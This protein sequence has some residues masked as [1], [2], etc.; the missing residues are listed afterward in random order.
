MLKKIVILL[1]LLFP[2]ASPVLAGSYSIDEVRI[3]AW[4]QPDGDLLVNEILTYN[5]VGD[6]DS[7]SRAIHKKNHKGVELFEAYEL[8][9]PKAELGYVEMEDLRPLEVSREDNTY[10]A[11]LP[12]KDEKKDVFF[13]YELKEAVKTYDSYSDLT[14]PF[15]G[16]D[17][18]H[19]EDLNKVTIDFVF[20][21]E[22]RPNSYFPFFH[23]R[24]GKVTEK[25]PWVVRFTTPESEMYSLTETRL[26]FPSSVMSEQSK[27][28]A[29]MSLKDAIAEEEQLA[30][31]NAAMKNQLSILENVLTGFAAFLALGLVTMLFMR[32]LRKLRGADRPEEL[33]QTDPLILYMINRRGKMNPYAFLA[34][35]FSLVEKGKAAVRTE[36][37]AGRFLKDDQSADQ[38]LYFTL[39]T[40]ET[41]L[42]NCEQRLVSWLF[43][44]KTK[45]GNP[46]FFMSDIAGA[47]SQQRNNPQHLHNYHTKYKLFK[48]NEK[49]WFACVLE[50]LKEEGMMSGKMST[51]VKRGLMLILFTAV[52]YAYYLD[53]L[54]TASIVIYSIIAGFLLIRGWLKPERKLFFLLFYLVSLIASAMLYDAEALT[55]LFITTVLSAVLTLLTPHMTLSGEALVIEQE[56]QAFKKQLKFEIF[57]DQISSQ[58][59]KWMIRS[60]LLKPKVKSRAQDKEFVSDEKSAAPLTYLIATGQNPVEFLANTWKWSIP[61]GSSSSSSVSGDS[62]YS[63]GGSSY[64]GGGDSGGGSDGGGAGAD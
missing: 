51:L 44:R 28:R 38:T 61:P 18:N 37:N 16:T 36:Q 53:F 2:I 21:E 40:P 35:L 10:R 3:R 1:V 50:V 9:N 63:G 6:Y 55:L 7:V 46:V 5:F 4:I 15:F 54:S 42:S 32:L 19:D 29:P 52:I 13:I 59:D 8:V 23:D 20:P 62:G 26:L 60:L 24:Q 12:A 45:N 43:R 25:G 58:S 14:V 31:K 49:E 39:T 33:L 64:S 57:P 56:I 17:T 22:L 27:T 11:A 48:E 41:S 47:S 34:G 30:E